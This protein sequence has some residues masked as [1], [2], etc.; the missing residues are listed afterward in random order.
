MWKRCASLHSD[1]NEAPTKKSKKDQRSG[2]AT[3]AIFHNNQKLGCASQD[4]ELP[5]QTVGP[6]NVRQSIP[7]SGKRSPRAQSFTQIHKNFSMGGPKHHQPQRA[8]ACRQRSKQHVVGRRWCEKEAWQWAKT[9]KR[10]GR[11]YLEN[12][13]TFFK[14]KLEQLQP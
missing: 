6:S 7:K 12:E 11:T 10:I 13:A 3:I 2:K 8:Y 14:P 5:E 9:R 1:N 4:D